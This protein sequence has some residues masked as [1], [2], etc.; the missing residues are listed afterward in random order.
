[1]SP[2][3]L[4]LIKS[5][6]FDVTIISMPLYL[7]MYQGL[8]KQVEGFAGSGPGP[9][10]G[11]CPADS[12][13]PATT[14]VSTSAYSRRL[15]GSTP[16]CDYNRIWADIQSS[17]RRASSDIPGTGPLLLCLRYVTGPEYHS[18]L[19]NLFRRCA[20]VLLMSQS[21][22]RPP[23]A[24]SITASPRGA[25]YPISSP[26]ISPP[27]SSSLDGSPLP[28]I[29]RPFG[30][31]SS[32]GSVLWGSDESSLLGR[33]KPLPVLVN[34]IVGNPAFLP[35]PKERRPHALVSVRM[36][37]CS[38]STV[39]ASSASK[40]PKQGAPS[41]PRPTQPLTPMGPRRTISA[42]GGHL[43]RRH[44]RNSYRHDGFLRQRV[45]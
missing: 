10:P 1:M 3:G 20:I 16:R 6:L 13:F 8:I 27:S 7:G 21:E 15:P 22:H 24:M 31:Q 25:L 14:R 19:L 35:Q 28:S 32:G 40:S 44:W 12:R 23:L 38:P 37:P 43:A 11:P 36:R 18:L 2:G 17:R 34:F 4:S 29:G 41:W 30:K 9:E 26:G 42:T 45:G 33:G 5:A 39:S